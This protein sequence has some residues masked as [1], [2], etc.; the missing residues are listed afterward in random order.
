M[1]VFNLVLMLLLVWFRFSASTVSS[2]L[3][4]GRWMTH[5]V[6]EVSR[7]LEI[8]ISACIGFRFS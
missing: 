2:G 3:G 1:S 5:V 8:Y 6:E 7:T 4:Q